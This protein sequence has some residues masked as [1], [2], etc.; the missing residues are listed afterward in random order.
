MTDPRQKPDVLLAISSAQTGATIAK[1]LTQSFS[2][3]STNEAE[4]AWHMIVEN[5]QISVLICELSLAIG[6][7]GL[8]ERLR[9]ASEKRV[10]AIPVLLLVGEGDDDETR[11]TA[12]RVGVTD[13]INMPFISSELLTRVRLHAQQFDRRNGA[14]EVSI[15]SPAAT[16]AI[17]HLVHENVFNSQLQQEISFSERHKTFFSVCK[18]SVDSF[19]AIVDGFDERIAA[20]VTRTV[21]EILQQEV[22]CEDTLCSLGKAEFC[23][24]YPVTNGIGAAVAVNRIIRKISS[25]KTKITDRHLPVSIS[26]AI[27]TDIANRDSDVDVVLDILQVRLNEAVAKGGNCVISAGRLDEKPPT[28]VDRALQL[29]AERRTEAIA[30]QAEALVK[31]ILPL[32]EYVDGA[33]EL[34]LSSVNQHLRE[35]LK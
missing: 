15:S 2:V 27:F 13:F 9:G 18:L 31:S 12:F 14:Q 28:S 25:C 32:L 19:E 33:L 10:F 29:I 16:N 5:P 1:L 22:R 7:F 8:L 34:G 11:E 30:P 35:R 24:L 20:K 3:A 17:K 21:A 26:A 6:Q 23:I 4:S